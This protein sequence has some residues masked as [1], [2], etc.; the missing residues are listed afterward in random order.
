MSD[1]IE[2]K[3]KSL[4]DSM[5]RSLDA[6]KI[7]KLQSAWF[8]V[9]REEKRHRLRTLSTLIPEL[10]RIKAVSIFATMH[11]E[12][13]VEAVIEGDWAYAEKYAEGFFKGESDSLR[14]KYDPLWEP[15]L[16]AT[17]VACAEAKRLQEGVR[18]E[19][20]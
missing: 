19:R 10:E 7:K 4:F 9:G 5:W 2:K 20:N 12:V 13:I 8:M 18:P 1:E 17:K 11:G 14:A 6:Y 16:V 3:F 15:F